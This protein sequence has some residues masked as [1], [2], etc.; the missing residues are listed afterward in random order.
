M[1]MLTNEFI[2]TKRFNVWAIKHKK[3]IPKSG[4]AKI[5]RAGSCK[6]LLALFCKLD[7]EFL[8]SVIL[9]KL[10]CVLD[11]KVALFSC[12]I[13]LVLFCAVLFLFVVSLEFCAA[14]F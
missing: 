14:L 9:F 10:F 13:R 12:V 2:G 5:L 1:V 7:C 11:S 3:S 6:I 8:F 4:I